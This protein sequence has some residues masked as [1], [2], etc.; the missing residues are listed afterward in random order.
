M[1]VSTKGRYG[2]R[3]M[4]DVAMYSQDGN[5]TLKEVAQRQGISEKYLW[6]LAGPLKTAGLIQATLGAQGGYVLA[7]PAAQIS[8][9]QIFEALEGECS[10]VSCVTAPSTCP[11]RTACAAH[12][13]W[14]DL[15][16]TLGAAMA[17]LSLAD[18]A[19]KQRAI[20]DDSSPTYNI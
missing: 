13:V 17:A 1:K 19:E 15:S 4:L 5:V 12:S 7:K 10:L 14:S 3:F 16:R 2:L 9:L 6:Q 20:N 8:V 18:V 11:S